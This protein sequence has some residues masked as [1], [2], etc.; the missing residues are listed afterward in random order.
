MAHEHVHPAGIAD[1]DEES[2][3]L[4]ALRGAVLTY[5][6]SDGET[7]AVEFDE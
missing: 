5:Q 3:P 4:T 1:E 6:T 2:I 7:V